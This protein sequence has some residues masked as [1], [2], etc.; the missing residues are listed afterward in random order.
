MTDRVTIDMKKKYKGFI[1]LFCLLLSVCFVFA[2]APISNA[3]GLLQL[4]IDNNVYNKVILDA[5][6]LALS[7]WKFDASEDTLTLEN[8]GTSSN[9]KGKIF[10]F[11]YGGALTINLIGDNYIRV[12]DESPLLVVGD[13]TFTGT[14]RLTVYCNSMYGIS[15]DYSVSVTESASLHLECMAGIMALQGFSVNTTGSVIINSTRKAVMAQG[16]VRIDGGTVKLRG[17]NGLYAS[18]GNVILS[19]G[20][21]DVEITASS[22]AI[23]VANE[24]N[25]VEWSANGVV[26]AGD[27]SP[28]SAVNAYHNEKYFHASFSGLPKLNVPRR[29]YWDETVF[30]DGASNP[31][32]RWT[33]VDQAIGYEIKLYYLNQNNGVYYLKDSTVVEDGLS[34]NFESM[35]TDYGSYYFTVCALGDGVNVH[36]RGREPFLCVFAHVALL[37]H[38]SAGREQRGLLRRQLL[39]HHRNGSRLFADKAHR[40]LQR[41]A[42]FV[43]TEFLRSR[44]R[45][46]QSGHYR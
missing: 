36:R 20:N 4:I 41:R 46:E 3:E 6:S 15:T 34:C 27:A 8:F 24:D 18:K 22:S 30:T 39:F 28:G 33:A 17:T 16:G 45:E 21:T 38:S 29:I 14:G 25:Y 43:H 42:C 1:R 9:P 32:G 37:Y 31:V 44:K 7:H 12:D 40:S 2:S 13:I 19:G 5:G 23:Y 11:P 10:A 35:F 26:R